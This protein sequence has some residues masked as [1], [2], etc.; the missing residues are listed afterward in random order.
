[1]TWDEYVLARH[2]RTAPK[3]IESQVLAKL[4]GRL[5][6]FFVDV[7]NDQL[8]LRGNAASYH[9][10]QLAQHEVMALTDQP[11]RT[12]RITVSRVTSPADQFVS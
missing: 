10:K 4:G 7:E 1:M 12:N 6:E 11:I 8:V 2:R 5:R 3:S 9:A